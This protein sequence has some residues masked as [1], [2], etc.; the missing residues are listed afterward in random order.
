MPI[1]PPRLEPGDLIALAAP[2]GPLR[3]STDL[4]RALAR[5]QQLGFRV[6]CPASIHRQHGFLAGSDRQRL[7][8]LHRLF[9]NRHVKAIL[10]VRGGYG[11]ARL[12]P[13]LDYGLIRT[14]P[15]IF[16]GYSDITALHCALQTRL[17]WITFHGPM[18][19]PDLARPHIPRFTLESLLRTLTRAEPAGSI[20][21][22][23]PNFPIR[24]LHPGKATGRLIGGNLS[25]LVATLGTPYQPDFRNRIL[26]LEEVNEPPY[27]I[28]RMLT[29][30]LHA[31]LL[32]QLAG[33]AIG[34]C[35]EGAGPNPNTTNQPPVTAE[36]V[37][38]ERLEPLRKPTLLGLPFGHTPS[39]AT[40]P[41]NALA[42]LDAHQGDLRVLEPAVS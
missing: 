37:F 2:A 14:R 16:I 35:K 38:R 9:Q 19:G 1:R 20:L 3:P 39:N 41:L 24:T 30:L 40:L 42:E 11:S 17:D 26:C 18:A 22:A 28:D 10:C 6:H 8:E 34:L 33:I 7:A 4:D 12:L 21:P 23:R 5:L 29:Q 25:V 13:L 15:K 31:G 36:D 32:Q 27:R